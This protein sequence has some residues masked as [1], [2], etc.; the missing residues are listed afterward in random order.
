ML[1]GLTFTPNPRQGEDIG[2]DAETTA[3]IGID[4]GTSSFRATRFADGAVI[5]RVAARA[6]IMTVEN[7]DFASVLRRHVG[8]WLGA[9]ERRVLMAGMIGSRQGW[10]EAPYLP[11]PASVAALA[12][13]LV[14]VPFDAAE[15]LL[16]PGVSADDGGVPEVMR[17][18]ETQ[19]LGALGE[20]GAAATV[21]MPG[22]HSKWVEVRDG[23]ILGFRTYMTGEAY[24]AL[25]THTILARLIE[26]T[27]DH[28]DAAFA[29]GVARATEAGGLLHHLFGVRTLPLTGRMIGAAAA[30][31]LSGLLLG[32]ETQAALAAR[33]DASAP[34]FL[35]GDAPLCARYEAAIRLCGGEARIVP[36]DPAAAGLAAI[37]DA[38][39]WHEKER[40]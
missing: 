17:G 32:H 13:S 7:N 24:A 16:V 2:D 11:C 23:Q 14:P 1:A 4:W 38:A 39:P 20:F 35:I 10:V 28:D 40:T 21:C 6:G 36:G 12:A 37:A 3:L 18:E 27:H 34:V 9:G 31:Y 5:D 8:A 19:I 29:S 15:V 33:R 25:S 26:T 30:S 22:T